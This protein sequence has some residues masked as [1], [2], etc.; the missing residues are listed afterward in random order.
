MMKNII[1]FLRNLHLAIADQY[2][3]IFIFE[4]QLKLKI[5]VY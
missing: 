3:S 4:I 2:F 5:F 1:I